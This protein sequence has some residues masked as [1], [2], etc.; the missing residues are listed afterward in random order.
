MP[1]F[2]EAWKAKFGTELS[3]ADFGCQTVYQLIYNY[4]TSCTINNVNN[5]D[6]VR[7]IHSRTAVMEAIQGVR[8]AL[9]R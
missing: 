4:A 1:Q 8:K 5:V 9:C 3:L 7:N 6:M 2:L